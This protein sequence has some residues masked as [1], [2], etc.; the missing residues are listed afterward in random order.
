MNRA[1]VKEDADHEPLLVPPRPPLPEGTPNYVTPRGL[2]RLRAELD[3]L[4]EAQSRLPPEQA[5]E[6]EERRDLAIMRAR[7]SALNDRISSARVVQPAAGSP[8]RVRFGSTVALR[9][10]A[11]GSE[12]RYTIVGVDEADAGS[13][14]LSFLA[15]VARALLGRE[16]G[17]RVRLP[18]GHAES[19]WEIVDIE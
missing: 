19:D 12:R 4:L 1:F 17:E 11:D 13:G 15:P 5:D 2:A 10:A 8:E 7:I 9:A 6:T 18:S 16:V 14:R 3:E